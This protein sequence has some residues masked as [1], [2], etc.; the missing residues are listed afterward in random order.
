[1]RVGLCE[2]GGFRVDGVGG[3]CSGIGGGFVDDEEFDGLGGAPPTA[4]LEMSAPRD[5]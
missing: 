1:M 2:F 5:C 4:C 3:G